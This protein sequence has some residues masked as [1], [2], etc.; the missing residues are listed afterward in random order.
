MAE[1]YFLYKSR[2]SGSTSPIKAKISTYCQQMKKWT[3]NRCRKGGWGKEFRLPFLLIQKEIEPARM[4]QKFEAS[5]GIANAATGQHPLTTIHPN[6]WYQNYTWQQHEP[7]ETQGTQDE[8]WIKERVKLG[9]HSAS[10]LSWRWTLVELKSSEQEEEACS[11]FWG[12]YTTA[13]K[14]SREQ[15]FQIWALGSTVSEV[16]HDYTKN[17]TDAGVQ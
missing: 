9:T 14:H 4:K 17:Q 5:K 7:R 12:I 10:L 3:Y 2:S 6:L 15:S 1:D 8:T 11:M 16:S 13:C